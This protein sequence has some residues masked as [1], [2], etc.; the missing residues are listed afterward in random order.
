MR[1]LALALLTF[2]AAPL[3][4]QQSLPG[5]SPAAS[6]AER[7]A[8]SDVIRRPTAASMRT[9]SR[10]LSKEPHVAGT[11]AQA[12]TRDYAINLMKSWG[13]ETEV[14]TYDIWLPHPVRVRA[15]R[16]APNRKELPLAEPKVA[17]DPATQLPQYPTVN[18]YSGAG[19]VTA[20]V[21]YVNYGLI[22]DYAQLDAAGVSV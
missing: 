7:T 21:V 10:D 1:R 3:A 17:G 9:L 2:A 22:E 16:I 13:L 15:W 4:A 12:R 8:E 5:F 11:P 6:T 14:R 20:E 18:G 19:D